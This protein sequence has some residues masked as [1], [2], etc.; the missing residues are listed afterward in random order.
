MMETRGELEVDKVLI[1]ATNAAMDEGRFTSKEIQTN[2]KE[3]I[4]LALKDGLNIQYPAYMLGREM[5]LECRQK[6]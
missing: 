6:G 4:E 5:A 3:I 1:R 2:L